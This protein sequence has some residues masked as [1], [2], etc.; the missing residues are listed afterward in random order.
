MVLSSNQKVLSY[1]ASWKKKLLNVGRRNRLINYR[2]SKTASIEIVSPSSDELV[3]QLLS[4]REWE[5]YL[6]PSK[7]EDATEEELAKWRRSWP[8]RKTKQAQIH[9]EERKRTR[10]AIRTLRR[11]SLNAINDKGFHVLYLAYGFLNWEE[12]KD[13]GGKKNVSHFSF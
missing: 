1:L 11:K 2:M 9:H 12:P 10:S 13:Q 7:P 5:F 4:G 3:S 8:K 6:P